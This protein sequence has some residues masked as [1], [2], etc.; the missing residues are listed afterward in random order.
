[1]E[2][3]TKNISYILQFNDSTRFMPSALPNLVNNFSGAIRRIK[4]KLYNYE[5]K[6]EKCGI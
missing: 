3:I 1:M 5:K 2:E 6:Y 4:R